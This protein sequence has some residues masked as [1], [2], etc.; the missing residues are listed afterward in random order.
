[1]ASCVAP[2]APRIALWFGARTFASYPLSTGLAR[3]S[4]PAVG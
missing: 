2:F 3:F 4:F 1:M